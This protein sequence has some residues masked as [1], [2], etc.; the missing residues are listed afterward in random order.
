[1]K[2]FL[3]F[4]ACICI[5][6]LKAQRKEIGGDSVVMPQDVKNVLHA[7][8]NRDLLVVRTKEYRNIEDLPGVLIYKNNEINAVA[9]GIIP[10]EIKKLTLNEKS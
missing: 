8:F 3:L 7:E 2:N 10:N 6:Q 9:L 4:A 5:C 1:M